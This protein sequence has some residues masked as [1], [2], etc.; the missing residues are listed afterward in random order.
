MIELKILCSACGHS[1]SQTRLLEIFDKPISQAS[2][3]LDPQL[4]DEKTR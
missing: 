1:F 3:H 2:S 4:W